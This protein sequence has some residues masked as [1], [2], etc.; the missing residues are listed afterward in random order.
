MNVDVNQIIG[1][2]TSLIKFAPGIL[3][4]FIVARLA[5]DRL[6]A[7]K[8]PLTPVDAA[9]TMVALAAFAYAIR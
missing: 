8:S 1:L 9:Y 7:W 4:W 3:G 2:V 5:W 6:K